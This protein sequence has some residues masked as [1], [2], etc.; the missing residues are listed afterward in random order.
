MGDKFGSASELCDI[1]NIN[2]KSSS[3]TKLEL[4]A[5]NIA[6]IFENI[7]KIYEI[8]NNEVENMQSELNSISQK[9]SVLESS[10]YAQ[11]SINSMPQAATGMPLPP[12]MNYQPNI[13]AMPMLPGMMPLPPGMNTNYQPKP[14]SGPVSTK[15]GL[16]SELDQVLAK[17]KKY[18]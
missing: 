4:V 9:V 12:G 5:Y 2:S 1:L 16:K 15:Q 6:L 11:P 17:R 3:E 8:M 13:Q 10:R 18:E 7:D 14:A